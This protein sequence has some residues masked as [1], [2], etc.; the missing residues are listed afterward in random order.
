MSRSSH[1]D[2][3]G[4]EHIPWDG[5]HSVSVW[6]RRRPVGDESKMVEKVKPNR[7]LGHLG[8]SVV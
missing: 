1:S 5:K 4:E 7:V 3:N 6:D 2:E 8:G